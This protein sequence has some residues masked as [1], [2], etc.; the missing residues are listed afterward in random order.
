MWIQEY[1][2][3]TAQIQR[4]DIIIQFNRI[5]T[6]TARFVIYSVLIW[7][8]HFV[9]LLI[10]TWSKRKSFEIFFNRNCASVAIR[11]YCRYTW[12]M[13]AFYVC[14]TI[15]RTH[16]E[17]WQKRNQTKEEEKCKKY[18]NI[19]VIALKISNMERRKFLTRSLSIHQF[20]AMRFGPKITKRIIHKMWELCNNLIK[21][22]QCF[23]CTCTSI[24][25]WSVW[26]NVW[27]ASEATLQMYKDNRS[28][29]EK[30]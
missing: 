24:I 7:S 27:W 13:N 22:I 4:N 14:I 6:S 25:W 20:I 17:N 10:G 1:K 12:S 8:F 16:E 30:S 18:I 3:K 29:V 9:L 15:W 23:K 21:H 19:R 2:N 5:W 28:L 26:C 11:V